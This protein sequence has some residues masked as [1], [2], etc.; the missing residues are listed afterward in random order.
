M[1]PRDERGNEVTVHLVDLEIECSEYQEVAEKFRRTVPNQNI[2]RITRIQNPFLY[3][4]YQLRK[5]KMDKDNE[6]DN[7]RKLFHGTN[8]DNI[9]KINTQGFD[10][11]F[12]GSAHGENFEM[13]T[14]WFKTLNKTGKSISCN[15]S[16]CAMNCLHL[17]SGQ[18]QK[19]TLHLVVSALKICIS[20]TQKRH[21]FKE[22]SS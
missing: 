9:T 13:I 8:P 10:R 17:H 7:E 2:I 18:T 15:K 12:S 20:S 5:Q 1:M 21:H 3:Q 19:P 22:R 16:E 4:S 6:G 14:C 11:S